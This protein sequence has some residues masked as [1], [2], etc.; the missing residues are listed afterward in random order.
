MSS[1]C[2]TLFY[3]LWIICIRESLLFIRLDFVELF[4]AHAMM[5]SMIDFLHTFFSSIVYFTGFFGVLVIFIG[6]VKASYYFIKNKTFWY[7][8]VIL[9]KHI[10]LGLDFLIARDIIETVILKS[11]KA[12]WID[13]ASLV[14]IIIIRVVFSFFAEREMTELLERHKTREIEETLSS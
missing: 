4:F 10:M 12:L 14:L 8:R 7:I 3:I 5:V 1:V 9:V 6:V 13:L 2:L 11:E